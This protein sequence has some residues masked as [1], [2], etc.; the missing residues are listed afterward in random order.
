MPRAFVARALMGQA[1]FRVRGPAFGSAMYCRGSMLDPLAHWHL[2]AAPNATAAAAAAHAAP[3]PR[4]AGAAAHSL[5]VA[6]VSA[7]A[8]VRAEAAARFYESADTL[9]RAPST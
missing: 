7:E 1:F 2:D 8:A 9:A 3:P 4:A 5:P 6:A